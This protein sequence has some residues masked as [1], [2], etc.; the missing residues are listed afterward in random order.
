MSCDNSVAIRRFAVITIL[1]VV[2]RVQVFTDERSQAGCEGMDS[3][4][5][6]R[7]DDEQKRVFVRAALNE[8]ETVSKAKLIIKP[9]WE[10]VKK[11]RSSW[12]DTWS[13]SFSPIRS[14][15]GIRMS[16]SFWNM[17]RMEVGREI[18]SVSRRKRRSD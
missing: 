17:L 3:A 18:T 4:R 10:V 6:I 14:T 2:V 9:V 16:H 1:L 8:I 11:C 13:A 7:L 5:I 12:G 15:P